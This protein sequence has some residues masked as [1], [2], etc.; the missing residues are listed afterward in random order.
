[1][2]PATPGPLLAGA[3]LLGGAAAA[4]PVD[5]C[6]CVTCAAG[7]DAAGDLLGLAL[8]RSLV[9]DGGPPA[10]EGAVHL[11]S[12]ALG[13]PA[14]TARPLEVGDQ[15]VAGPVRAVALPGPV[16]SPGAVAVVVS[17][18][19]STLLWS[20]GCGPLPDE[21]LDVLGDAGLAVA[22]VDVRDTTGTAS[23]TSAAHRLADLRRS[24]ALGPQARVVAVG[25]DHTGPAA[26][27][28]RAGLAR[29]GVTLAAAGDRPAALPLPGAVP[30]DRRTLVL[31]PA[32]SGKS[33]AAE[34]LLAAEPAVEYAATG[35]E[36]DA[37]D[38]DWTAK[39]AAHR[40]RR[41]RGW[42]T[43]EASGPGALAALLRSP[44]PPVLLDSLGTWVAA[45]L[46]R[47]GAWDATDDATDGPDGDPHDWRAAADAEVADLL[48]AWR[49]T[50][51]VVVAVGEEV[52][53]G[54]VPATRSGRLFAETLGDLSRRLADQT[55][56]TLLVVAG[57]VVDLDAPAEPAVSPDPAA[58]GPR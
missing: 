3:A 46:G 52:G 13:A 33:A 42:T 10:P 24:G 21:T 18:G 36:P 31:G 16:G 49:G 26:H 48:D 22:V 32:S 55:E 7:P 58:G 54:V 25:L 38:A 35:P 30:P 43:V 51:R 19:T 17:D 53:W 39:V 37:T 14:A 1:M 12:G 57:R 41:P 11:A 45:V 2:T 8:G 29:H 15:V 47:A 27:R 56:R 20:P 44:G 28:V 50:R 5:G 40:A 9:L 6:G 4:W 23:A 34:D